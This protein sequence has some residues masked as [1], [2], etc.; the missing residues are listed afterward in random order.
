VA[1]RR[2]TWKEDGWAILLP[3]VMGLI[4]GIM[5][6]MLI[7]LYNGGDPWEFKLWRYLFG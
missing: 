2:L 7:E 3:C 4:I 1:F 5:T 6:G